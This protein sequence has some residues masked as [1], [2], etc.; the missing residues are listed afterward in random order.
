MALTDKFR[1][2]AGFKTT[3]LDGSVSDSATS[4][5]VDSTTGWPTDTA[6]D[7]V[8]DRVDS[9]GEDTPNTREVMTVTVSGDTLTTDNTRRGLDGTTRQ[10][11]NAAAVVEVNFTAD[12]WNDHIDG[13]LVA[14]GQDGVHKSGA[15]YADPVFTGTVTHPNA[16]VGVNALT[17]SAIKLGYAQVTSAQNS[18]GTGPTDL[19]SLTVTVTAPASRGIKLTAF[20]PVTCNATGQQLLF[21]IKEGSTVLQTSAVQ[22]S[23]ANV[24]NGVH[25]VCFIAS[26]TTGSHTYKLAT[27]TAGGTWNV[28]A[29]SVQPAFILAEAV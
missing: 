5:D 4:F 11:H 2:S 21:E 15:T 22:N 23:I 19:T 29:S 20:I 6:M 13:I 25:A 1:K 8:V 26:P 3:T 9:Q 12:T 24:Q 17:T 7:I 16:S 18:L 28:N 10:A 14:H 27:E